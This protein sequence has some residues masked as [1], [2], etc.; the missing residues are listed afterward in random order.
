MLNYKALRVH[1][2]HKTAQSLEFVAL[3][4]EKYLEVFKLH[5]VLGSAF[6]T[7]IKC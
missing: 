4:I 6:N 3:I 7:H 5:L 2:L 1:T